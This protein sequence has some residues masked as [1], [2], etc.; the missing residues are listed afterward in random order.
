MMQVLLKNFHWEVLAGARGNRRRKKKRRC[1]LHW[2]MT[3]RV[4]VLSHADPGDKYSLCPRLLRHV[5][6]WWEAGEKEKLSSS[7]SLSLISSS[8][9]GWEKASGTGSCV[10][11]MCPLCHGL[12]PDW[13]VG[14]ASSPGMALH[15]QEAFQAVAVPSTEA[16]DQHKNRK[17]L[18]GS[19]RGRS[20]V[21][22]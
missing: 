21:E 7:S 15:Q 20:D 13:G 5:E 22:R 18:G 16:S 3:V 9:Q 14:T 1:T 8:W 12:V 6:T 17:A 2:Q 4:Y 19:E 11:G 10:S